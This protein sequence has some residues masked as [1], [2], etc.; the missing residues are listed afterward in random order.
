MT[1]AWAILPPDGSLPPSPPKKPR[2][3]L[4]PG[5][6]MKAIGALLFTGIIF[7][8]SFLAYIVFNPWEAQFFIT[9]FGIDTKD[10]ASILRKFI[11][12]SFGIIILT[13][14][15]LWL[16]TLFRAIW[17][18]REQKRKK[19]LSWMTAALIGVLLFS[20]LAFW[21]YLFK[22]IG[23]IVWDGGVISIYDNALYA[24][25]VSAGVSLMS[26]TKN[27]IGPIT[28]RYDIRGNA[29]SHE[30]NG[31]L[32]IARY[33]INFDGA[34][35]NDGK[36]IVTGSNPKEEKAIVCTFDQVRNY[37]IRGSYFGTDTSGVEK[38]V[39][40]ELDT[41]EVRGL[42]D[43][44]EQQN[45]A[46]REIIT[47][48]AS[49]LKLL[50]DPRWIYE[51]TGNEVKTPSIT[52][53]P[54]E[55]AVFVSLKLF[56]EGADRIFL[57]QKLGLTSG[58]ERIDAQQSTVNSLDFVLTLTGM[59]VDPN[60]IVAI[61]W[62]ANDGIIICRKAK[63]TCHFNFGSY[64]TSKVTAK[65]MLA[66]KTTREVTRELSV[67]A[68]VT[69]INHAS[70]TD[71]TGKV[72]NPMSSYD[73]ILRTYIITNVVPPSK[74]NFDARDVVA[75][76]PGY[77]LKEVRWSMSD[78]HTT[79]EKVSERVTF[80]I[81]NNYRYTIIGTYTFE[82]N[83]PGNAP[84]V[85]VS[86]D[87]IT[88]D[89]EHKTLIPRLS[90]ITK[91]DYIPASVTV[92]ASQ[93]WSENNNIIKFIYNFGEGKA[94]AVGDAIQTYEYTTPGEKEITLTIID[95]AGEKSQIKRTIVLKEAP[96]TVD[97]LPSV[98]PGIVGT[99]V[100]F[101]VTGE[102][103]QIETYTWSFSDNTPSQRGNTATHVFSKAGTYQIRLTA[104]YADGTQKEAISAFVVTASE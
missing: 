43:I 2:Q 73:A 82:K 27:I 72:M 44:R 49:R 52:L 42:L 60:S 81:L 70:V 85:K 101:S 57:I 95:E 54:S 23:E 41:V 25:P 19:I 35:C 24:N 80:D 66:D 78:W 76:N 71:T 31:N 61:E 65:I 53:E 96:R 83:V 6:I 29:K 56:G 55:T 102:S 86:T 104:T 97:F 94:D 93:S 51:N 88:V 33:E 38:E 9:M 50:G 17:T 98:S 11:N 75:E 59:T 37:N 89:V 3:P 87:N 36:S 32:K 91:S 84:E 39:T 45:N 63:E 21:G 13:L 40:M 8:A 90:V 100:D 103:G 79:I 46:G 67:E 5:T 64:G 99:P 16:I 69:L 62:T 20:L 28:L 77:I 14:S 47:L 68:P 22:K 15:I 30:A 10:V 48:D 4:P 74:L 26:T 1:Q 18:P 12:G 7:F 34:A 92:D 58:N